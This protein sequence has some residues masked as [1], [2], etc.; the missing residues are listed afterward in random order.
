MAHHI[1]VILLLSLAPLADCLT[2][3]SCELVNC[4]ELEDCPAGKVKDVCNCCYVCAKSLNE[5]CGGRFDLEGKCGL[6]L[7]CQKNLS[8][9]DSL[10]TLPLSSSVGV[11]KGTVG[12]YFT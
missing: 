6:G 3:H 7:Y 4:P 5:T 10:A 8:V 11:C 12:W 1:L 2:C 9:G